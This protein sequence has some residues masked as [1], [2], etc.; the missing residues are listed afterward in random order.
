MIISYGIHL[1]SYRRESRLTPRRA[2]WYLPSLALS[3][4][5]SAD[6]LSP[7]LIAR[8]DFTLRSRAPEGKLC[9]CV[10][11]CVRV[12][13]SPHTCTHTHAHTHLVVGS[14]TVLRPVGE[15]REPH[16]RRMHWSRSRRWGGTLNR[17]RQDH[18]SPSCLCTAAEVVAT[19]RRRCTLLALEGRA[20]I[21]RAQ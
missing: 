15:T 18:P 16:A 6:C 5:N 1:A 7:S 9:E 20:V 13:P 11:I 3:M 17:R 12:R 4:A 8:D 10:Y 19:P 21:T 2:S 14:T